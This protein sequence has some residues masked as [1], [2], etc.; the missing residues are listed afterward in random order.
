MVVSAFF[1]GKEQFPGKGI[2]AVLTGQPRTDG[3]IGVS[4][5]GVAPALPDQWWQSRIHNN[6]VT[7]VIVDLDPGADDDVRRLRPQ[8]LQRT[9]LRPLQ[10]LPQKHRLVAN[11]VDVVDFHQPIS[12]IKSITGFIFGQITKTI[13][14]LIAGFSFH[15]PDVI[16]PAAVTG[17]VDTAAIS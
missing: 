14:I 2:L 11:A 3:D 13:Y 7:P 1:Q 8:G 10:V 6:V 5:K 15:H 12:P 4:V 17:E 16:H 9:W